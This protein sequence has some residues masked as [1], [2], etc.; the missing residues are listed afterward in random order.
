MTENSNIGPVS[1]GKMASALDVVRYAEQ[2]EI[3]PIDF[4]IEADTQTIWATQA[5]IA[6]LFGTNQQ[7]I[8]Y[9]LR[10]VFTEG[11]LSE[12]NNTKNIG[13]VTSKKPIKMYSLDAII[14]VGYRVNS[15]SA[16]QFRKWATGTLKAYVEQGYVINE[17]ALRDSPGKLNKLA[18]EVRALRAGEKQIYAKVRECFKISASDYDQSSKVVR[19]FYALLKDKFLHAVTDQTSSKLILDRADHRDEKMG[20]QTHEGKEPKAIEVTV[21]KNYLRS[22]E[23]YRLHLLSE[24]F[25]LYAES[26]ALAGK[27]MTMAS[28]HEQLDRLLRLNEYPVFEG[29][30]DFLKD[31]AVR[32]AKAE[33]AMYRIRLKVEG[34]C[35]EYDETSYLLG[36]YDEVLESA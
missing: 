20:L 19:K 3:D 31:D 30:K 9:H 6:I 35:L 36:D 27:R 12:T 16:T 15:K 7:N 13:I 22:D 5:Q 10:N 17:W 23:L 29:Y 21:G 25:L 4:R 8:S 26:T 34:V 18:K 33:L 28:L 24:Q 14:S 11:E 32:H 1:T 2:G